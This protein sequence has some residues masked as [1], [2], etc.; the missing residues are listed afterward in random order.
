MLHTSYFM[1]IVQIQFTPWDKVYYFDA[2]NINLSKGDKVVVNTDLGMEIGEVVGFANSAGK[3]GGCACPDK[4]ECGRC[5]MNEK[6]IK[7]ILRLAGADDLEKISDKKE[8]E[9]AFEYCRSLIKKYEMP[10]K[11]SGARFSFDGT[12]L[13][14]AFISETRIDFRELVKELTRHFNRIIRMQQIGIRDEAKIMGDLGHCGKPLC[15]RGHLKNL[16]SITSEMAEIQQCAHRG[17][18]RISGIC[19]RLMCC[20]AYE[21]KGYEELAGN[22]PSIGAR[23]NVDGKRGKIIGHNILKQSVKVKFD[24]EKGE[25]SA[26]TEVDLNRDK[27]K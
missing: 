21:Q 13:T 15:C 8:T 23:V 12:K 22:M 7:P 19:G 4:D 26:V 27:R 2:N 9:K 3:S 25:A 17:S 1:K 5:R 11:L 14:F 20:L 10:M 6:E 24:G 18:D 16:E